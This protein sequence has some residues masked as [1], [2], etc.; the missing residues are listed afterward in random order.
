MAS[1]GG[2]LNFF[3]WDVYRGHGDICL[4]GDRGTNPPCDAINHR[5]ARFIWL[6]ETGGGLSSCR[7]AIEWI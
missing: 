6:F 1:N 3:C 7:A 4:L 5:S 2:G